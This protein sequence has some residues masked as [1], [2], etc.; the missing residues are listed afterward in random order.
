MTDAG[1][2]GNSS[3]FGSL[4]E[5]DITIGS[6]SILIVIGSVLSVEQT[7]HYMEHAVHDTP[8]EDMV[9]AIEKELMIV[10]TMAFILKVIIETNSD[11]IEYE[12]L[13]ALHFA[14]TLV[15]VTSFCLCFIGFL[16]IGMSLLV[17]R[18]WTRAYHYHLYELLDEYYTKAEQFWHSSSLSYL[19]FSRVNSEMEFRIFHSIFC[20][21]F[22]IQRKAFAFDEYVYRKYE[23]YL[24]MILEIGWKNWLF[25]IILV[26]ANWLR[27]E[28]AWDSHD[29]VRDDRRKLLGLEGLG[30]GLGIPSSLEAE[31]E[32]ELVGLSVGHRILGASGDD[33]DENDKKSDYSLACEGES[34]IYN[35]IYC[36]IFLCGVCFCL[37]VVAR[38]Y[39]LKL[40]ACRGIRSSDDYALYLQ[41]YEEAHK[42]D[43]EE[44]ALKLSEHDLR[45]AVA[46][47]KEWTEDHITRKHNNWEDY[48]LHDM[49]SDLKDSW[50]SCCNS[51]AVEPDIGEIIELDDKMPLPRKADVTTAEQGADR[52]WQKLKK[53]VKNRVLINE[54]RECIVHKVEVDAS[55]HLKGKDNFRH[56]F[57]FHNP[58]LFFHTINLVLMPIALY[59]ALW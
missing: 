59:L 34:S 27:V 53:V 4:W 6:L 17:C 13:H 22:N 9:H 31:A 58:G 28:M 47:A 48:L 50:H 52:A 39:E 23:K 10:G 56:L 33:N 46:E 42:E 11:A 41:T 51:H 40:M 55:G 15:P 2:S 21:Q 36:G 5:T 38:Y 30:L 29:C 8:F 18:V 49:W 54:N 24:L 43:A 7:F 12:W 26:C 25:V 37:A 3:I 20:E 35:F 14:D 57:L 44:E 16:L 19:P 1:A 32:A 45:V